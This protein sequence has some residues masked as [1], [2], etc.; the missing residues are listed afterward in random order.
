LT[1]PITITATVKAAG[2]AIAAAWARGALVLWCATTA[3]VVVLGALLLG[4]YWQLGDAPTLLSLHGTWI[5]LA[6]LTCAVAAGFKTYGE[7]AAR[8]LVLIPIEQRSMWG[9]AKQPSGQV[10]TTLSLYFQATN[11]SNGTVKPSAIR[12]RKPWVRNRSIL[13]TM[14]TT[15]HPSDPMHSSEYPILPHSLS[16]CH[17]HIT[18]DHPVGKAGRPM[19]VV[20]KLQ[21]HAGRWYRLVFP[22]VRSR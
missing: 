18:I 20:I 8:P 21:D 5:V 1:E 9:Q 7:R 6:T 15:E 14:L 4:A 16:Y 11:V 12:L 22:H 3:G 13:Q 19:R 10:I 17:A 2:A